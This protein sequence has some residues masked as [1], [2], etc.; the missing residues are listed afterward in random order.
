M[1]DKISQIRGYS[2]NNGQS[3]IEV[4]VAIGI[5]T[6]VLAGLVSAVTFSLSNSQFARNKAL[7]TKYAQEGMEWLRVQRDSNWYAFNQMS[8]DSGSLYCMSA[9][10]ATITS[11]PPGACNTLVIDDSY[12]I[13]RREVTLTGNTDDDRVNILLRVWW[14][15]GT[16]DS[17]VSVNTI[18]TK[19]Q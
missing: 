16:R 8:P 5:V 7:A 2:D 1:T 11:L 4:I 9:L 6:L 18:L 13:F 14:P 10:P 3:L 12:D 19:W 15:Q 17:E